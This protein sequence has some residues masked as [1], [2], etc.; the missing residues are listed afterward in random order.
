[1]QHV[2]SKRLVLMQARHDAEASEGSE[3]ASSSQSAPSGF[4]AAPWAPQEVQL[5]LEYCVPGDAFTGAVEPRASAY[6]QQE[7]RVDV[8][9]MSWLSCLLDTLKDVML[10]PRRHQSMLQSTVWDQHIL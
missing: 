3:D 1:M 5:P 8:L 10:D 7:A 9:I 2:D 4:L 6:M